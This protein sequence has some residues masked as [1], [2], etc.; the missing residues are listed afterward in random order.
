MW[1]VR[2]KRKALVRKHRAVK[3]CGVSRIGTGGSRQRLKSGVFVEVAP[4]RFVREAGKAEKTAVCGV[5]ERG[6]GTKVRGVEECGQSGGERMFWVCAKGWGDK[7][8]CCMMQLKR[9]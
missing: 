9:F 7:Q 5:R 8:L 1:G 4:G 3:V 2:R 6:V